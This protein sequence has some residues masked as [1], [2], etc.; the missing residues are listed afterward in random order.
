MD[1]VS[2]IAEIGNDTTVYVSPVHDL[3]YLEYVENNNLGGASGYFIACKRRDK[4]EV[5]AKA[6][7]LDSARTIFGMLTAPYRHNHG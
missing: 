6:T 3:T 2:L 7:N 5:L 4:F 1:D